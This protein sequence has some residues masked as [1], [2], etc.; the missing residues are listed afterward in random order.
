MNTFVKVVI[1]IKKSNRW[2]YNFF[3]KKKDLTDS[4]ILN[5]SVRECRLYVIYRDGNAF[6]FWWA[7]YLLAPSLSEELDWVGGFR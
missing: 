5:A 6:S 3:C 7:V 4:Y 2:A 1:N